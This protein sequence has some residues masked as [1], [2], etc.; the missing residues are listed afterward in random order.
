MLGHGQLMIF[1][2]KNQKQKSSVLSLLPKTILTNSKYNSK[3]LAKKIKKFCL[4]SKKKR[5]RKK[6]LQSKRLN[7]KLRNNE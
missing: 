6:K 4:K 2:M 3:K 1:L 7:R 5:Q